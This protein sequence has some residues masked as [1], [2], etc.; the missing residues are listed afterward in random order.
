MHPSH[1][2]LANLIY[3]RRYG[4]A[5]RLGK[6]HV[7]HY[8]IDGQGWVLLGEALLM[9]GFGYAASQLFNRAY[10]LDPEAKWMPQMQLEL[11]RA[12]RGE[13]CPDIEQLLQVPAKTVAAAIIVKNEERCIERCLNSIQSAVDEIIVVDSGST[14][15]TLDIIRSY[16]NVKL[17]QVEWK[18]DFAA[19]RNEALSRVT[20][21]WVFWLDADEWLISEDAENIRKVAG[22]FDLN[23]PFIPALQP[24][25]INHING[26]AII[27]HSVARM[28]PTSKGLYYSGRIHEQIATEKEGI[29]TSN[30]LH[31][32]VRIRLNHDGYESSV[33]ADKDKI[34]RNLR[35]L[36]LMAEEEPTN[37][38]W[39]YFLGRESMEL[40]QHDESLAYF[41]KVIEYGAN[42]P[43]FGRMLEIHMLMGRIY[44]SQN[45]LDLA[46]QCY[47]K[48]FALHP[49]YPDAHFQM[50]YVATLQAQLLLKKAMEHAQLSSRGFDTYRGLVGASYD[51]HLWKA[52][53]LVA[54]LLVH[55]GQLYEGRK[56]LQEVRN[57]L[58]DS[59]VLDN[60]FDFIRRQQRLLN[61]HLR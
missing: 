16:S 54:D 60:K 52:D 7:Q 55:Q 31:K 53:A 42:N 19:L 12:P 22:M 21:E 4:E 51:I 26:T 20:S 59:G 3:E 9:Q 46:E 6:I 58:P 43:R 28:F 33:K 18:D 45:R 36:K 29:F 48:A 56:V 14:D 17:Y 35:L 24:C 38:G 2:Q 57:R 23:L 10:L 1:Q 61:L 40:G 39:W 37:P 49:D 32:P 44:L 47:R 30:V 11:E 41:D 8:P 34:Q 13:H 15:R 25:L 50:A 27:E 5:E